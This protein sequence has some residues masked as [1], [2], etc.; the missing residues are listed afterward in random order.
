MHRHDYIISNTQ[1]PV[2]KFTFV[3]LLDNVRENTTHFKKERPA[4]PSYSLDFVPV[5]GSLFKRRWLHDDNND[6][7]TCMTYILVYYRLKI[8]A[9]VCIK[10]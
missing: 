2:P 1:K 9:V 7:R 8:I 4:L 5:D 6:L 3:F 10:S